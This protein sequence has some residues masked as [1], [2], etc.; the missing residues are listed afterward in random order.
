M[1]NTLEY[2]NRLEEL[3]C[4]Y[5]KCSFEDFGIKANNNLLIH[6]WKSPINFA[7]GYAYAASGNNKELKMKIDYFLGNILKGESIEKLI[8]NYEYHGYTCE[9]DAFNYINSTIEALEKILFQ[10]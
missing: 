8:E 7:L 1:N 5:L 6:D 4:R 3:L 10:K 2:A 9:E